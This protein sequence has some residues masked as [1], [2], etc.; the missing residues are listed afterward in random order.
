MVCTEHEGVSAA[1]TPDPS[2]L[3]NSS[4]V[5]VFPNTSFSGGS[6]SFGVVV[7]V[8]VSFEGSSP[9]NSV[10]VSGWTLYDLCCHSRFAAELCRDT[11]TGVLPARRTV[12]RANC[13]DS[14]MVGAIFGIYACLE[15]RMEERNCNLDCS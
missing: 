14:R 13:R 7:F 12:L 15:K 11:E 8:I 6:G 3:S 2:W 1:Y 10:F 4:P 9:G 5:N